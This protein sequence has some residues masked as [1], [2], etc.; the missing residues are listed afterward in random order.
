MKAKL[1]RI[2][3]VVLAITTAVLIASA[4]VIEDPESR[5][6]LG[7]C[8]AGSIMGLVTFS[9]ITWLGRPVHDPQAPTVVASLPDAMAAGMIVTQ[10]ESGGVKAK[11]IGGFTSGF[12]TEVASDVEVVVARADVAAAEK[13]LAEVQRMP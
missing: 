5:R 1:Q 8:I 2:I 12:Q 9:A 3:Q 7:P 13:I 10:L 4:F 11:A 6:W